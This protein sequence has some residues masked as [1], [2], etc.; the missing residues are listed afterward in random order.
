MITYRLRYTLV[1]DSTLRTKYVI[2]YDEEDAIA[3]L[4]L[5]GRLVEC[6]EWQS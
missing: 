3:Q 4:P 5:G 6:I 1:N 2:G